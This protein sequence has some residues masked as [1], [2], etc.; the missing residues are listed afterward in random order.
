[1]LLC[2]YDD[3][4][5]LSWHLNADICMILKEVFSQH[6]KYLLNQFKTVFCTLLITGQTKSY[7]IDKCELHHNAPVIVSV[8]FLY[9]LGSET[10]L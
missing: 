9:I 1:M 2:F 8:F 3:G 6:Y 5:T 4:V 10:F 7:F